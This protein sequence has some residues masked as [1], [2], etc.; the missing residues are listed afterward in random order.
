MLNILI[1][2]AHPNHEGFHAYFLEKITEI[3]NKKNL[4]YE[5]LD[6]YVSN[7]QPVLKNNE[8]Y[9]AGRRE[10]AP[11]TADYQAKIKAADSLLFIY[12]TWWQNMPAILKGFLD[13]TFVSHFAYRYEGKFP[14][15]LLKGKKAAVFTG[16]GQPRWFNFLIKRDRS[17]KVLTSDVLSFAG[18]KARG[19]SIGDSSSLTDK[20]RVALEKKA[21]KVVKYLLG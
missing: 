21:N 11:E 6:L 19:F 3:L 16:S 20:K 8:L 2:Y 10:I 14:T 18:I 15:G 1:I 4:N 9:T 7:Y 13:R 5:I 12:P 17:L